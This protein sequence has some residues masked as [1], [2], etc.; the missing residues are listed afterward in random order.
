[1][2]HD[3]T[4]PFGIP[5][6]MRTL[7]EQ[8]VEQAKTA[9]NT[10]INAA[11]DAVG[12]FDAQAKAAQESARGVGDK[13]V[14]YAE[15]NVAAAFEHAQKIVQA[16]SIQEFVKLQTEFVQS[17]MQALSEQAK[18]LGETT[19]KNVIDSAKPPV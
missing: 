17:Q 6:D 19:A 12:R 8:S 7:A 4:P 2:V 5:P 11:H 3:Q 10:F 16:T 9:F 13:A 18:D 1:M 14:S 15:R